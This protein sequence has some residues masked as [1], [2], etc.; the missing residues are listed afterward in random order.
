MVQF[1]QAVVRDEGFLGGVINRAFAEHFRDTGFFG[2]CR[3]HCVEDAFGGLVNERACVI[4][5]VCE[6]VCALKGRQVLGIF[7]KIANRCARDDE[8]MLGIEASAQAERAHRAFA[9]IGA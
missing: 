3:L 8:D 4:R 6:L 9:V 7:W 2:I 5:R 1:A